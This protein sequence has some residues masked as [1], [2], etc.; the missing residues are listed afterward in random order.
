MGTINTVMNREGKNILFITYYFPPCGGSGV[1]RIVRL[2]KNLGRFGWTPSVLTVDDRDIDKLAYGTITVDESYMDVAARTAVLRT[3]FVRP[4]YVAFAI[5]KAIISLPAALFRI[6]RRNRSVPA[7]GVESAHSHAVGGGGSSGCPADGVKSDAKSYYSKD[8]GPLL[9]LLFDC[10]LI[11]DQM[12][13]WSPMAIIRGVGFVRRHRIGVVCSSS[14]P[15]GVHITSLALKWICRTKWVMD[16][17]DPFFGIETEDIKTKDSPWIV[18][19]FYRTLERLCIRNA[20]VVVCNC[21]EIREYYRRKY[22]TTRFEVVTNG[23]DPDDFPASKPDAAPRDYIKICHVGELYTTI[24]T[25]DAFLEAL[26]GLLKKEPTL[27]DGVSVEILGASEYV[28]SNAFRG[29]IRELG[30]ESVVHCHPYVP[31]NEAVARMMN[32]DVLLLLQPHP[33]TN[34]Q[35]PAKVFEYIATGNPIVTIAPQGSAT[36]NLVRKYGLG[37]VSDTHDRDS[38]ERSIK[39]AL[40]GRAPAPSRESI[41]YFSAEGTTRRFAGIIDGLFETPQYNSTG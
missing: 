26:A 39:S 30:I 5:L 16:L 11:V 12:F 37:L 10:I 6:F 34:Y 35:I 36:F 22:A 9:R 20:D 33:S 31:H 14:P 40:E 4:S 13:E 8:V 3:R 28:R 19:T 38:I 27:R 23:F 29:L 21:D 1:L 25:P 41:E 32:A 17:R 18:R 7:K 15:W 2:V 24:R